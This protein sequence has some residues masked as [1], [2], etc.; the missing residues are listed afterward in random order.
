MT[1]LSEYIR[2]LLE[3]GYEEQDIISFLKSRG[4]DAV[5]IDSGMHEAKKNERKAHH[6]A[7]QQSNLY[8]QLYTYIY[9]MLNRGYQARQVY[10]T[11]IDQG[12][13]KKVVRDVFR[14]INK[15][16][17]Q[18]SLELDDIRKSSNQNLKAIGLG[19][20]LLAMLIAA[21]VFL[22]PLMQGNDGAGEYTLNNAEVSSV[23]RS[24]PPGEALEVTVTADAQEQPKEE[25]IEVSLRI[26]TGD[27]RHVTESRE[28]LY[29]S[30]TTSK[31]MTAQLPSDL[32]NGTYTVKATM[33]HA[34]GVFTDTTRFRVETSKETNNRTDQ[35]DDEPMSGGQQE[36]TNTTSSQ[37][38]PGRNPRQDEYAFATDENTYS[39]SDKILFQRALKS[40]SKE[41]AITHCKQMEGET[42]R[43][44]CFVAVARNHDDE[45]VCELTSSRELKEDCYIDLV[46]DGKQEL[47]NEIE[48]PQNKQFCK[49]LEL[50]KGSSEEIGQESLG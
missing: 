31:E 50:L 44:E 1:A 14:H 48:I 22:I 25:L 19:I 5:T 15:D 34:S 43:Y 3:Q 13:D 17:Y 33:T 2:Q 24:I 8:Q 29:F 18:G 39:R 47:C 30:G 37:D 16:Y 49:E 40:S 36:E 45:G 4:Y 41:T 42:S 7:R 21:G 23:S 26:M 11:L 46:L 32:G 12:Y 20:I 35:Q 28:S 10:G 9:S 38:P 27:G 6:H